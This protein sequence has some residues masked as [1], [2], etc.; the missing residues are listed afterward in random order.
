[1]STKRPDPQS[2]ERFGRLTVIERAPDYVTPSG[3]KYPRYLCKCD[4]G[5]TKSIDKINLI[6]GKTLSC[7][8][9][10]KE[11]ASAATKK[12]GDTDSRLYGVWC[13]IKRR[14]YNASVPEYHLY[15][16]RG[17]TMCDEWKDNY[18]AFRNWATSNGYKEGAVRGECTIDRI[19]CDGNYTPD[20]CRW[21][22]M[23]QQMNNVRYNH[24]ET[25]NGESH[26]IAEWGDILGIDPQKIRQRMGK[27]GWS[28][29]EAVEAPQDA[30]TTRGRNHK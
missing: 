27:Y 5:Q 15:G 1:M 4:C 2:G 24:Y 22:N 13:A 16:G 10:Q 18:E 11:R 12:H 21:V 7:G 23:K 6:S 3:K 19:D 28:F 30:R 20:N 14:C 9:M 8:C 29:A 26:T 25:Y 17:I